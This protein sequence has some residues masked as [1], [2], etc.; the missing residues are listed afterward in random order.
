MKKI[1]ALLIIGT[2]IHLTVRAQV[3]WGVSAGYNH[4]A[5]RIHLNNQLQKTGYVP[6]FNAAARIEIEFEPPL[7]FTGLLG[8]S[9]RGYHYKVTPDSAVKTAINYID[10]SPMLNYN[11]GIGSGNKISLMAGTLLGFAFSGKEKT[12]VNGLRST[13]NMKF[14][15]SNNYSYANLAAQAGIGFHFNKFFIEGI[16]QLGLNSINSNEEFDNTNIKLRSISFNFGY[17]LK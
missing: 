11:I 2:L 8:V 12:T 9:R 3:K 16:Y 10:I 1:Y 14:S 13:R 17:W 4:N 5:A 15:L 6:G 7:H